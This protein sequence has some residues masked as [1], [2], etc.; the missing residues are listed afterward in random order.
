MQIIEIGTV[1]IFFDIHIYI[2]CEFFHTS[3]TFFNLFV[4]VKNTFKFS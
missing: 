4:F 1:N 2:S 3:V